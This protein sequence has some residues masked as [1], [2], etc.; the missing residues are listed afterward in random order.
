MLLFL[1]GCNAAFAKKQLDFEECK[2]IID[3]EDIVQLSILSATKLIL[4]QVEKFNNGEALEPTWAKY[5][6]E[7]LIKDFLSEDNVEKV[8][9]KQ[10]YRCVNKIPPTDLTK[11]GNKKAKSKKVIGDN[12]IIGDNSYELPG[13]ICM[14]EKSEEKCYEYKYRELDDI[15]M[16]KENPTPGDKSK[17]DG[18]DKATPDDQSKV[19]TEKIATPDDQSKGTATD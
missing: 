10:H 7:T 17:V 9:K 15:L 12:K 4:Q 14:M 3:K 11:S 18:E 5:M 13:Y 8:L 6:T 16:V 19:V 1:V 2:V